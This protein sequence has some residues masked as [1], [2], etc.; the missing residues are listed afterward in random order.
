[1]SPRDSTI[2]KFGNAV[3]W[4]DSA[5]PL[6]AA[7]GPNVVVSAPSVPVQPAPI[8]QSSFYGQQQQHQQQQPAFGSSLNVPHRPQADSN[9]SIFPISS[10]SPYQNKCVFES[11]LFV[12]YECCLCDPLVCNLCASSAVSALTRLFVLSARYPDISA[13]HELFLELLIKCPHG[14]TRHEGRRKALKHAQIVR[15]V[16]LKAPH[17][18]HHLQP[19]QRTRLVN[20]NYRWTIRARAISKSPIRTWS[21]AKGEG[22]L[23]SVTLIDE[24]GEIRVS[25]F[26][27]AVDMFYETIQE[28]AVY[29]VS[30]AAVKVAR[31]RQYSN[32]QNEYEMTFDARTELTPVCVFFLG[33]FDSVDSPPPW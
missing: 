18:K 31:N 13:C 6:A 30:G 4:D 11:V 15:R 8:A 2:Q 23:F 28:N 24:S 3:G 10:L 25:G 21:N 17:P 19:T 29:Y 14:D 12:S 22:R 26:N 5:A 7:P 27:E 1:M 33:A 9:R 16:P 20:A 32:V